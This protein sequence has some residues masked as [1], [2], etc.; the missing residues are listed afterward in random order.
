MDRETFAAALGID[1]ADVAD[2]EAVARKAGMT[3]D[4][5]AL[6]DAMATVGIAGSISQMVTFAMTAGLVAVVE[7]EFTPEDAWARVHEGLHVSI[8]TELQEHQA[9][10]EK[11]AQRGQ[12]SASV[13]G[14]LD[15]MEVLTDDEFAAALADI[16]HVSQ[17]D[18]ITGERQDGID[19]IDPDNPE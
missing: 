4:D 14:D 1:P 5:I 13:N 11:A 7:G 12:F 16:E 9:M 19:P 17:F 18:P 3:D 6:V 8:D 10:W 2:P 15:D